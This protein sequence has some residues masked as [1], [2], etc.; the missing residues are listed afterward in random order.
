VKQ[1]TPNSPP[2]PAPTPRKRLRV[3]KLEERIAPKGAHYNPQSKWVG[4]GS[5]STSSY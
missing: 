4:Q 5:A 1:E 3:Q 2:A